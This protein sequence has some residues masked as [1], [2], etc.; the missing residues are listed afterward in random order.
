MIHNLSANLRML[1]G[2]VG[3]LSFYQVTNRLARLIKKLPAEQLEESKEAWL[4]QDDISMVLRR[5]R[6]S[7]LDQRLNW[8][9]SE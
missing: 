2:I 1:L 8:F 6:F 3:E 9:H 4:T 7:S 5:P